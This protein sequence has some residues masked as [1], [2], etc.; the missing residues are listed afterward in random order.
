MSYIIQQTPLPFFFS[1]STK[2]EKTSYPNTFEKEIEQIMVESATLALGDSL[3]DELLTMRY[4]VF[5]QDSEIKQQLPHYV[6]SEIIAS[7]YKKSKDNTLSK[8]VYETLE[9]YLAM[10][11]NNKLSNV[12]HSSTDK[13]PTLSGLKQLYN[14]YPYGELN[15]LVEWL[16]Y[17][18]SFELYLIMADKVINDKIAMDKNKA[19]LLEQLLKTSCINFAA[20]G[21]I[22][23][24]W[25]IPAHETPM[26]R[27]IKIK[28]ST[29]SL[30]SG[31]GTR[32]T[33]N[34]LKQLL[35]AA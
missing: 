25:E 8:M 35:E 23:G 33:M 29:L 24:F 14:M 28:A 7:Y 4:V 32:H 30:E 13:L 1:D 18:L 31:K 16:N 11:E 12:I 20:Y 2:I 27:N 21:K 3:K 15:N 26:L 6:V 5:S 19:S 17:S 22:I 10:L 34:S 9:V